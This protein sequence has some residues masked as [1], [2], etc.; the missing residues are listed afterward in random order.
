MSQHDHPAEE[1]SDYNIILDGLDVVRGTGAATIRFR[2]YRMG[3]HAET[4]DAYD[5]DV[6]KLSFDIEP[7]D[8][9][10]DGMIARAHGELVIA[11]RQMMREAKRM[12]QEFREVARGR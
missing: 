9:G 12:R 5:F 8:D 6:A 1:F 2:I 7:Q 11:L 3:R 4:G 10:V